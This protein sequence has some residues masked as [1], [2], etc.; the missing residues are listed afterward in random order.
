[1]LTFLL[2]VLIAV[3]AVAL[4]GAVFIPIILFVGLIWLITLPFRLV[5]VLIRGIFRLSFGL[6]GALF[7]ILLAPIRI[8]TGGAFRS[9]RAA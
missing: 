4:G 5:L 8:L 9:R 3:A 1:M 6:V 2:F 7:L